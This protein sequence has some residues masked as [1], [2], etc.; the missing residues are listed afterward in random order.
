[1]VDALDQ[2]ADCGGRQAA[3]MRFVGQVGPDEADALRRALAE[4]GN[5]R[6]GPGKQRR[7]TRGREPAAV[8]SEELLSAA[9]R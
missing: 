2:V 8:A 3:L 1:M 5:C 6:P 4:V 7:H 9:R